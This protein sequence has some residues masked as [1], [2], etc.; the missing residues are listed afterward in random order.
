VGDRC[1]D[2]DNCLCSV[3][4]DGV[5]V[6]L[7]GIGAAAED[8][9][10]GEDWTLKPVVKA[11]KIPF[12]RMPA[13]V[14]DPFCPSLNMDLKRSVCMV[15]T[16]TPAPLEE[17]VSAGQVARLETKLVCDVEPELLALGSG[18]L[19]EVPLTTTPPIT[20]GP[21]PVMCFLWL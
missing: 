18:P 12:I 6:G 11:A 7:G 20:R 19:L 5:V 10:L 15:C 13:G 14:G 4:L 2:P 8:R 1:V 17:R 3:G 21:G 16:P 9:G